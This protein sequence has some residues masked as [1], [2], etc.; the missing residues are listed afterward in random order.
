MRN[1]SYQ[2]GGGLENTNFYWIAGDPVA[3]PGWEAR[4]A[5]GVRQTERGVAGGGSG[6]RGR[7]TACDPPA[8]TVEESGSDLRDGHVTGASTAHAS[9]ARRRDLVY[10][11]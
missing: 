5:E 6:V 3:S 4:G 7:V 11:G 2:S 9:R 8:A 1:R 10:P